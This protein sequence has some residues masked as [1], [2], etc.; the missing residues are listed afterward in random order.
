M[1]KGR[2]GVRILPEETGP[3]FNLRLFARQ[4]KAIRKIAKKTGRTVTAVIRELLANV[5]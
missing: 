4:D 2:K 5:G 1:E 3:I